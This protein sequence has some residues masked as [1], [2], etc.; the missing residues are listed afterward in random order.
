M[1]SGPCGIRLLLPGALTTLLLAGCGSDG[2]VA[3]SG[4]ITVVAAENFWG[5]IAVQLGGSHASVTSI[6]S[7]PNTDPHAYEPTP[8][9][10]RAIASAQYVIING[11][12]YD[13]W[14]QKLVDANPEPGRVV[15]TV[16]DLAGRKQGDNPHMWYDPTLVTQVIDKITSDYKSL[17]PSDAAYFDAQALTLKSTALKRYNDLRAAI[18]QRYRGVPVGATESI[19]VDLASDLGLNL[20]TPSGYMKAISEGDDPTAADKSTIDTQL[21][22]RA[23]KVLVFNSQNSTPDIQALIDKA[24][25]EQIPVV[26]ITETLDPAGATFEDWQAR[27]LQ[28]LA[29]ALAQATAG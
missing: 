18:R 3:T 9:D 8:G 22:T 17:D 24:N 14:V 1:R 12:G 21:S 26:A 11:A 29:T 2:T 23:I 13:P 5:S 25:A 4:H 15:L 19:F 6:V 10:A 7:N 28:A 16:A 20:I 27:Q